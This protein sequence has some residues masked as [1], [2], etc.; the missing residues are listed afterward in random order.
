LP[1]DEPHQIKPKRPP[2]HD[3]NINRQRRE[4]LRAETIDDQ[5]SE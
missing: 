1:P 4:I 5:D 3:S 2:N